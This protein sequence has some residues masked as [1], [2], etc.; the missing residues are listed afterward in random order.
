[1]GEEIPFV[2]GIKAIAPLYDAFIVDLW[3]V[4]YEENRLCIG[5]FNTLSQLA[6]LKKQVIFLSNTPNRSSETAKKIERLGVKP[7][8]YKGVLTSGE[9]IYYELKS[10]QNP[11][12][13]N[14]GRRCFHLGPVKYI[15]GMNDLGLVMVQNI[16]E[17]EFILIN[18]TFSPRDELS[19]Y[20]PFFKKCMQRRL[21][22]ICGSPDSFVMKDG[23]PYIAAGGLAAHYQS[24]GG[25]VF[26]RGKPDVGVFN[27][28]IGGFNVSAKSRIA[29]IGDSIPS[30]MIGANNAGLDAIFVAGGVH[31]R[32]LGISRGQ[33]PNPD[34]VRNLFNQYNASAKLVIPAFV[35]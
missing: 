16:D 5:A 28:C 8:Q 20:E 30:D 31:A 35:W 26:W 23:I 33:T 4:V 34:K 11:F 12:F 29:V 18:G 13:A 6:E 21:P 9:I 1:M 10:R 2:S 27:Y 24:M 3:G 25:N 15:E 19:K 17:A 32:E 7:Y 14:L 22:M